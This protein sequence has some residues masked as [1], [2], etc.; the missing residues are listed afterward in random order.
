MKICPSCKTEFEGGEVF[1]PND[2]ARLASPSQMSAPH[3]APKDGEDPLVGTILSDRYRIKRRIGEGGMGLVYEAEHVA[4]E[5]PVALKVLR[6]DFSGR[7]EVVERFKQEAKSA[8]RIGNEHIV[9]ISDFGNTPS[10]ASYFVMELLE[11]EDL[12]DVLQREGTIAT[13]RALDV[14]LQCCRALGAAHAKGIV[15]RDMK[16]ENI[17]L[18]KRDNRP[19]FVKIVDF[20]IAKMSDIETPGAPGRKLTKTGMI[21][22]TPEYM[23]PE[24]AAGKSLDHRVD[25]YALAVILYEMVTGRVPFFGDTF[26]GILTQHRFED[27]PRLTEANPHAAVPPEIEAVIFKGLAKEPGERFQTCDEMAAAVRDAMEGRGSPTL[28]GFGDPVKSVAR[29]PRA[30]APEPAGGEL[31]LP[32]R[33]SRAG[34]LVGVALLAVGVLGGGGAW[35]VLRSAPDD[36]GGIAHSQNP[37]PAADAGSPL[38]VDPPAAGPDAGAVIATPAVDA[39][40]AMVTIN[41]ATDPPGARVFVDERGEVCEATPCSFTTAPGQPL[42]I[43]ARRGR[44]EGESQI[45][46]TADMAVPIAMRL[47]RPAGGG[48]GDTQQGGGGH[49]GGGDLKIPDI[50]R[51][52]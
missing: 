49:Q 50:F 26:M 6:D 7:P 27:P 51:R 24:Q 21:F 40:P 13:D 31:G 37:P 38:A 1:C 48:G 18:T 8:S 36:G 47:R 46:P 11:G 42:L 9:D 22:G 2:G 33:K 41:V 34:V 10:G 25:I 29:K 3:A 16:P 19:D 32:P 45:T 17:F 52:P 20:G 4:I 23:S 43:R 44:S 14:I 5:K 15:H 30:V 28:Y 35:Y 39:G 12:A